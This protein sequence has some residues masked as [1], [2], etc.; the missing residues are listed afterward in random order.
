MLLKK[1]WIHSLL[2][3]FTSSFS[4][5]QSIRTG[6]FVANDPGVYPISGDVTMSNTNG[7]STVTFESNFATIQG[8][9]LEVF[10]AKTSALNTSTDVKISL[11]PLDAGSSFMAPI[12]GMRTFA[13]PAG[14]DLLDF[15]NILVQ[16]TSANVLWGHATL[17]SLEIIRT[18]SFVA[19]DPDVYPI[20][21]DVKLSSTNGNLS[22][23]FESNFATIQGIT[24]EVFLAKTSAL[25]TSTDVKISQQPLDAGSSFMAPITGMRTFAVPAGID[26]LDFDNILVQC[27]SAN[28]LWGHVNICEGIVDI[29]ANPIPDGLYSAQDITS[30]TVVD[31]PASVQFESSTTIQL[32]TGFEVP[33]TSEFEANVGPIYGCVVE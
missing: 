12:T 10:L 30:H 1:L 15:D 11:Q 27:T 4:F 18:G 22:V 5:A 33:F 21:G 23:T 16:C 28:V 7:I 20:S 19:N 14:I 8:I 3:C 26:L 24:L 13:V 9:T 6:S 2:I 32:D 31:V 25:N 17:G 29:V